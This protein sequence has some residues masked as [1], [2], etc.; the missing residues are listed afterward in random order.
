MSEVTPIAVR[1]RHPLKSAEHL[2][3]AIEAAISTA[4]PEP[5]QQ[6]PVAEVLADTL[7]IARNTPFK[8]YQLLR[9]VKLVSSQGGRAGTAIVGHWPMRTDI[10]IMAQELIDLAIEDQVELPYLQA[11]LSQL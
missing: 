10:T 4:K 5:G 1:Y 7:G 2:R 11:L 6:L 8:A 9:D 3:Y